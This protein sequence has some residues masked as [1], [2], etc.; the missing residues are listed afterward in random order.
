[1]AS[2]GKHL[3]HI[4]PLHFITC[5]Y[6]SFPDANQFDTVMSGTSVSA[7]GWR[8]VEARP[9]RDKA[10]HR[11]QMWNMWVGLTTKESVTLVTSNYSSSPAMGIPQLA[12]VAMSRAAMM[13]WCHAI[14]AIPSYALLHVEQGIW[15]WYAIEGAPFLQIASTMGAMMGDGWL[16]LGKWMMGDR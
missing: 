4:Y 14:S 16:L 9:F 1:M 13:P 8:A 12:H 3:L 10:A 5:H 11:L 2:N 15:R 7:T 6:P